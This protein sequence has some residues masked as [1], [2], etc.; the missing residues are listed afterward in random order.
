[1]NAS[2]SKQTVE[3]AETIGFQQIPWKDI[4]ITLAAAVS[5]GFCSALVLGLMVFLLSAEAR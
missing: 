2:P 3:I 1:M 4:L 5:A